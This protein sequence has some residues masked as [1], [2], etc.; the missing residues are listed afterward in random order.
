MGKIERNRNRKTKNRMKKYFKK[1]NKLKT[2]KYKK[3]RKQ[4]GGQCYGN[5]VGANSN[6]P[7]Y[8]IYNTNLLKL[9]PYKI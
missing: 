4:K 9:F 6:E 2:N 5:G 7:N 3:T 8:S 1:T